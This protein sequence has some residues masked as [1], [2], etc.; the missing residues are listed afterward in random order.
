MN[1]SLNIIT[2]NVP[3]PPDYGGI[4]DS[5][6]RIKGLAALDIKIHLHT[7][8]YNRK[9]TSELEQ[10]CENIFY[11]N[12]NTSAINQAYTIPFIVKSRQNQELLNNLLQNDYPILFDGLHVSYFLD[13]PLLGKRRKIVRAHNIEHKYY[14]NL[15]KCELNLL[16]KGYYVLE[17][18]R[19]KRFEKILARADAIATVSTIDHAYFSKRYGN[20][21]FIP[22]SHKY[23]KVVSKEGM[24]QYIIYHGDLSVNENES[25][26][27]SII[28]NIAPRVNF[29]FIIA[30][31]NPSHKLV[32]AVKGMPNVQLITNPS[33]EKMEDLIENAHIHLLPALQP[34]GLKLKLLYALYAGRYCV[35]NEEMIAGTNLGTLCEIANSNQ[36]SIEKLNNLINTPFTQTLIEKR[37][38]YLNLYYSPERNAGLFAELL[39]P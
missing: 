25:V 16:K 26:V 34:C 1:K 15:A 5:F 3:Y 7:F 39:I 4:I 29:P 12:R 14:M 22:S 11:Y 35:V 13:H 32:A 9:K 17:A 30:G 20:S 10:Y 6:Y 2:L 38:E 33:E 8:K 27:L 37:R 24:G 18:L 28:H 21:V 36:Q 31:K 23:N 19:L